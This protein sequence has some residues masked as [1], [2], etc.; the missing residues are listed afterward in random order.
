M[1]P[2]N[3]SQHKMYHLFQHKVYYEGDTHEKNR[4]ID[5]LQ[6]ENNNLVRNLEK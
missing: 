3:R 6:S 2:K 5:E 1:H 4:S